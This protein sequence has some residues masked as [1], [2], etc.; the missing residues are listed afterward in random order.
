V[1]IGHLTKSIAQYVPKL[2]GVINDHITKTVIPSS[3]CVN[4]DIRVQSMTTYI[5]CKECH[6]LINKEMLHEECDPQ[7]PVVPEQVKKSMGL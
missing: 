1:V 4:L 3:I 5:W 6:K 2:S 7:V